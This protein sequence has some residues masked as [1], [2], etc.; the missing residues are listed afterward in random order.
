MNDVAWRGWNKAEL[1]RQLNQRE[2][3][4]EHS[5]HFSRWAAESAVV[6]E[7][8]PVRTDLEYGEGPLQKLDYVP[9]KAPGAPLLVFIHGG[10]WQSLDKGDFTFPAPAFREAGF[11][12]ASINY[13]LAPQ[14]RIPDMVAQVRAALVWLY[15][16]ADDLGFDS[17]RMVVA[18]H[19]AGGHLAVM[20]LL[21]DW[22]EDYGLPQELLYGAASISGIYDLEPLRNS[23][24][25]PVLQ[26]DEEAV[27][28]SSPLHHIPAA[29]KR[30][31]P[32]LFVAVGRE[33]TEEFQY[34]QRDFVQAWKTARQ[35][36]ESLELPG[37]NH[38]SIVDS[39][40]DSR[41][42]VFRAIYRLAD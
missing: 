33:E 10:Y 4:P 5:Q 6:R 1:D 3:T 25:Q 17:E 15:K 32:R 38:F 35:K 39:L 28:S 14:V 37:R 8:L 36:C 2:H 41:H 21:T 18:G 26:L 31:L 9:P 40:A 42:A 16:N 22:Q 13:D 23:Y 19:S 11:A 12:Y 34:Q 7:T 27:Q 29:A 30:R 24:Q 20:A